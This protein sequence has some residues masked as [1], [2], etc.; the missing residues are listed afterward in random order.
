V[1]GRSAI[2]PFVGGVVQNPTSKNLL[3]EILID[4]EKMYR[5]VNFE[6][7]S[8]HFLPMA[9]GGRDESQSSIGVDSDAHK[10]ETGEANKDDVE[11]DL[12]WYAGPSL[13]RTNSRDQL[14]MLLDDEKQT[15]KLFQQDASKVLE[16]LLGEATAVKEALGDN[17]TRKASKGGMLADML[18][19]GGAAPKILLRSGGSGER[20]NHLRS[21]SSLGKLDEMLPVDT[22]EEAAPICVASLKRPGSSD[23]LNE[24]S[25]D[26]SHHSVASLKFGGSEADDAPTAMEEI[27]AV[28]INRVCKVH[29]QPQKCIDRQKQTLL[30]A[31][32]LKHSHLRE[33]APAHHS[34]TYTCRHAGGHKQTR[35]H[36][37]IHTPSP[38]HMGSRKSDGGKSTP[39][40]H[41]DVHMCIGIHSYILHSHVHHHIHTHVNAGA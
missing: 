39:L 37:T 35:T 22:L 38:A 14:N 8:L 19:I 26:N 27:I 2:T 32:L 18:E 21:V 13:R 30:Y 1:F 40:S 4:R 36:T 25:G 41:L 6:D 16:Q 20:L 33:Y 34:L 7:A 11:E 23:S 31:H 3:Q 17:P 15:Q 29:A 12:A 10:S 24:R 28:C 5:L 9:D